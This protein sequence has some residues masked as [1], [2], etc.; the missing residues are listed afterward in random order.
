MSKHL[1]RDLQS[2]EREIV[3][4]GALVEEAIKKATLALI[5][6]RLDLAKEV[7]AGDGAIDQREVEVEED[8]LKMLA[9]H[10]PL[11]MDLRFIV[12]ILKVN[13]DLERMGD[14]AVNVAER[15][16]YLAT[17]DPIGVSLDFK[18]M[19][20]FVR[21]MVADS[22]KALVNEDLALARAVCLKDDEVDRIN[23]DMF[24]ALQKLMQ[25]DPSTI[26]RAVHSLSA[27]RHLE[28]IADLATN[29][30]EEVIFMVA[31]E[32]VRHRHED[33]HQESQRLST[34]L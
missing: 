32:V 21:E 10:Q 30:A 9:L 16:S 33:Y 23:K 3:R 31:G 15:A 19:V 26:K 12:A 8:C 18:Q 29:I 20:L 14:L 2:L 34:V 7:I 5:D 25:D 4:V 17:H 1:R 6:R 27:S 11:A 13:N 22:L 28:R 24:V